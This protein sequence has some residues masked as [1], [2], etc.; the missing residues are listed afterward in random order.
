MTTIEG[1]D[2][3]SIKKY[4][5]NAKLQSN[6][7]QSNYDLIFKIIIK[8]IYTLNIKQ[9]QSTNVANLINIWVA[10]ADTSEEI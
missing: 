7:H 9:Y 4:E 6:V 2:K 8:Y 5:G 1:K 3:Y 10:T